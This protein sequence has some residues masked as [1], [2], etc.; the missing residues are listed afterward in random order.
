MVEYLLEKYGFPKDRTVKL[1]PDPNF[2]LRMSISSEK[3]QKLEEIFK[4]KEAPLVPLLENIVK[5][6]ND[7]IE[8]ESNASIIPY[9]IDKHN[10]KPTGEE[11]ATG[12]C[13]LAGNLIREVLYALRMENVNFQSVDCGGIKIPGDFHK[14]V[15]DSTVVYD[16]KGNWIVL[17]SK[18]SDPNKQ[19][20]V[21]P[22]DKLVYM[23]PPF[24]SEADYQKQL[25]K[26][27]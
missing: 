15:H 3:Q 21:V 8:Y 26:K 22:K 12:D 20:Y 25:E 13:G 1:N 17:N 9:L 18:S 23:G 19:F 10:Y 27:E 16:E 4:L 6:I 5:I 7:S 24:S 14:I 11:T 2:R